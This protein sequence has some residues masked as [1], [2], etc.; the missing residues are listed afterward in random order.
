MKIKINY[1]VTIIIVYGV[2]VATKVS[3]HQFDAG[4]QK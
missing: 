4:V 2:Y 1:Y 3:D